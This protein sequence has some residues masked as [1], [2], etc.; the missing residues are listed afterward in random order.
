[1]VKIGDEIRFRPSAFMTEG[2]LTKFCGI[3]IEV[4]GKVCYINQ[5]H[6]FY[7]VQVQLE[8]AVLHECFKFN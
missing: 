4:T 6:R 3:P 7:R 5:E 8:G 2:A 1:M